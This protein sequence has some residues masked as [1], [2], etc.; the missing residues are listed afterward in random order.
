MKKKTKD[1]F[2]LHWQNIKHKNL[3]KQ[4]IKFAE[5][6][7]APLIQEIMN[8]DYPLRI[9]DAGCGDGVHAYVLSKIKKTNF[10]Y[11]GID[12]SD[13]AINLCQQ[14][15]FKDDRFKFITADLLTKNFGKK[16]DFVISYGVIAYT[17]D[18]QK[19]LFQISKNMKKNAKFLLWVYTPG[20]FS[21]FL[22]KTI[23]FICKLFGDKFTDI[24]ANFIVPFMQ[25]I[26]ISSG[27]NLT[28]SSFSQCKETILVN[29]KPRN[30]I[31]P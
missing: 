22:L 2:N 26:P 31:F 28:N 15:L 6:F 4:K 16:F 24:L 9:L 10:F 17:S 23:R 11:T 20:L 5:Y 12:I 13:K 8:S 29:I 21:K 27:L 19:A 3:S 18:P 1:D 7:L 30:L 14:K 25:I